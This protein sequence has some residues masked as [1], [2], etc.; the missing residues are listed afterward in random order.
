[1]EHQT[2]GWRVVWPIDPA[3]QGIILRIDW[4]LESCK[5]QEI[6]G[7][8]ICNDEANLLDCNFDFGDCCLMAINDAMC[9]E[10]ECHSTQLVHPKLSG[11]LLHKSEI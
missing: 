9:A 8:G 4:F 5:Y 10:C 1:M 2:L 6:T 7:D 11:K 3:T